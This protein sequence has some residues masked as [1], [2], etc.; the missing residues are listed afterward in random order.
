MATE[1]PMAAA[2]HTRMLAMAVAKEVMKTDPCLAQGWVAM[3]MPTA[4]GVRV[5]LLGMAS[6]VEVT[7]GAESKATWMATATEMPMAAAVQ[8]RMLAMAVAKE[9]MKTD[10][11]LAQG[12]VAMAMPTAAGERVVLDMAS[13][14]AVMEVESSK[15]ATVAREA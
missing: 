10:P 4:A 11:C 6:V 9:V 2:V 13:V 1:M 3:A 7:V 15:A 5:V 14:V 8:T 12:G